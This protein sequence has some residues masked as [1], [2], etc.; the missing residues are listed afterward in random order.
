VIGDPNL[1]ASGTAVYFDVEADPDRHFYYCIGMR[2][3]AAGIT[4]QR[5]FWAD[6]PED[7][8]TTWIECL[9]TLKTIDSPPDIAGHLGFRWSQPA[10]SGVLAINWRHQWECSKAA[11]LKQDLLKYNADDCAAA[12]LVSEAIASFTRRSPAST[13]A[14]LVD[15][16]TLKREYPQHFGKM[17]FSIPEFEQINNAAHWDYQREK[18]YLRFKK[19]L[20]RQQREAPIARSQVPI[21]KT[22]ECNERRPTQCPRC[23][24]STGLNDPPPRWFAHNRIFWYNLFPP[25]IF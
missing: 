23:P 22:V 7:E 25:V 1:A 11:N 20:P 15:V 17:E 19:R 10:A 6:A 3:E 12:Q 4:V 9:Q 5:S 14:R 21:N 16:N 18:V 13:D 8:R 24:S 2:Y